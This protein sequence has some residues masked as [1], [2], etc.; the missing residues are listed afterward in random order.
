MNNKLKSVDI[1]YVIFNNY[2]DIINSLLSIKKE[3]N[4]SL[5]IN[6]FIVDNSFSIAKK[7]KIENL[8][9]HFINILENKTIKSIKYI[10]NKDNVGFGKAC[11][12]AAEISNSEKILFLN[13]DTIFIENKNLI[14]KLYNK[15]NKKH[16]IVGPLV[17]NQNNQYEESCFSFSPRSILLKPL[18]TIMKIKSIKNKYLK[19]KLYN[20]INSTKYNNSYKKPKYVDWISGCCFLIEREFFEYVKGFDSKYFVYFE[21]VDL[22]RTARH[23]NRDV[24]YYP[25]TQIIHNAQY[26]SKRT[27]GLIFTLLS[28]KAARY[29]IFSWCIYLIK[30]R[31]DLFLLIFKHINIKG[32]NLYKKINFG[33]FENLN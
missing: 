3:V 8:K 24:I 31:S 16:V 32:K 12:Q 18:K 27:N 15:C 23:L 21:D 11:N 5:N 30:W 26:E 4:V 7:S 25:L 29:H 6:I 1:V 22:C 20:I 10:P 13:C 19:K 33:R 2:E 17:I 14:E 9:S 28:N